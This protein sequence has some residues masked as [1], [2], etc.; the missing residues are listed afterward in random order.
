MNQV[1]LIG[2]IITQ[3]EFKFSI[4]SKNI[5]I[6]SFTIKTLD[7]QIINVKAYNEKAD[8]IYRKFKNSDNIVIYG[9]L[10]TDG[11]VAI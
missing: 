10:K 7:N 8:Y 4:N 9:C 6:A 5:S 3:I 2:K 1:F 11:S